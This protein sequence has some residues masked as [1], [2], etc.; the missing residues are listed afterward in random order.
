MREDNIEC[1][2]SVMCDRAR[3]DVEPN[4]LS[5][6]LRSFFLCCCSFVGGSADGGSIEEARR[7]FGVFKT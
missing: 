3:A 7:R 2:A 6:S 5:K 4:A 1:T